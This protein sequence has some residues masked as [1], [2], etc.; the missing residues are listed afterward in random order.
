M[1]DPSC[2]AISKSVGGLAAD[3]NKIFG[4]QLWIWILFIELNLILDFFPTANVA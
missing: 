4:A 3:T 1:H 2:F